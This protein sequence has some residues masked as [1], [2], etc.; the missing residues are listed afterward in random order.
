MQNN[1]GNVSETNIFL[2]QKAKVVSPRPN[3]LPPPTAICLN[4]SSSPLFFS[5]P[6]LNKPCCMAAGDR[7]S[8][9]KGGRKKKS[10]GEEEKGKLESGH[11]PLRPLPYPTHLASLF[12]A[13]MTLLLL[14]FLFLLRSQIYGSHPF[15]LSSLILL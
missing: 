11:A 6:A 7:N 3:T 8:T 1:K 13:K 4:V 12:R 10:L 14:F 15:L 2:R 9:G 5:G